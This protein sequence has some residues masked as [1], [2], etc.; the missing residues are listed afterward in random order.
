[1]SIWERFSRSSWSW[2]GIEDVEVLFDRRI[3]AISLDFLTKRE[4]ELSKFE[5]SIAPIS[6]KF[7]ALDNNLLMVMFGTHK[8]H[9]SSLIASL[10]LRYSWTFKDTDGS[11]HNPSSAII[12]II[13]VIN[14]NCVLTLHV[15][16]HCKTSSSW[17]LSTLVFQADHSFWSRLVR[18][19]INYSSTANAIWVIS[20]TVWL[21][22][23]F[24]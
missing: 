9:F 12:D 3:S 1:M 11:E 17:V 18:F 20:D 2:V 5:L 19:A 15:R 4:F 7:L 22:L 16:K 8:F 14:F 24:R 6:S 23:W 21:D 13:T 10:L